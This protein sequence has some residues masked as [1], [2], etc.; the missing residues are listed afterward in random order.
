MFGDNVGP[1]ANALF[2]PDPY[3]LNIGY[4][5]KPGF[6]CE[7]LVTLV[8]QFNSYADGIILIMSPL[9]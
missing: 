8:T 9:D 7:H 2:P 1:I 6:V 5:G 3:T 4:Y